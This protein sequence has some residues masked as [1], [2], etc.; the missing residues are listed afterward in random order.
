MKNDFPKKQGLYNPIFEHDS[1]GIG[2]ISNIKGIK[3]N[4]IIQDAIQILKSLTHR[5]GFSSDQKTGDGA[6]ILTQI[7]H[8]FMKKVCNNLNI[9]LPDE[10]NYAVGMFFCSNDENIKKNTLFKLQNVFN[11]E[12]LKILGFRNVPF[13]NSHIADNMQNSI[14]SILQVFI[15]KPTY[16][17]ESIDFERKLFIA[18]KLAQKQIRYCNEN[19]DPYFYFSSLSSKT[20]VYKGLLAPSQVDLFYTD[21]LDEDFKTSIA[22]VHSRFSTNT[23]PNWERAHPNKYI[24]HNGEINTIRGNVNWVRARQNIFSSEFF[25]Q[26]D[27]QKILPVINEDGSDSA[28]LDNYIQML[29]LSGFSLPKA[30]MMAIPEPWEKNEKFISKNKK[31][32]YQYNSLMCEPWD[33]PAGIAFTDGDIVGATLDRNGLRPIRYYITKDDYLILSSEVG[34]L[35]IKE[36]SIVLK[37]RLSAGQMLIVDTLK[38]KVIFDDEIKN[39]ISNEYPYEQWIENNILNINCLPQKQYKNL[40]KC[41]I[42]SL[43]KVFGYHK[44]DL[45]I[46]IKQLAKN[47][48]E[49]IGAMGND[50]PLAIFSE[51]SQLIYNYFKQLFAQ[52]T[53]PPIDAIREEIITSSFSYI[54]PEGNLLNQEKQDFKRILLETPILNNEQ[55]AKI[56]Y[57][58]N[59]YFKVETISILY[60]YN[61]KTMSQALDDFLE[62]A[63]K[64]VDEGA[65]I[66]IISDVGID[67]ENMCIPP[68][69]ASAG[70]HHHLIRKGTRT[71]TSIVLETGEPREV[72]HFAL[73]VG[74]GANAINP[75]LV[76][77]SIS[78]L[79]NTNSLENISI[80]SAIN[81]YIKGI[82]KGIIKVMSKMGISTLQSYQGA[83]IF[84]SIGICQNVIDKFFT[85]T[86]TRIEGLDLSHIEQESLMRFDDAFFVDEKDEPLKSFGDFSWRK[87]GEY[88]MFNPKTVSLLQKAVREGDYSLYKQYSDLMNS[89][90]DGLCTIRSMFK[91][92]SGLDPININEVEPVENIVKRFKTGAM[93]Y[94]ALSPEAH[95]CIAIGMN[96][97]GG[98]SNSGEGGEHPERFIPMENGDFKC[99]QIKQVA[100]GRFGVSI[101]YLKNANEIQIK[102]A[103]GAKPGEGGHL[104]GEKVYPWVAKVRNST[105]GVS[106][107][108]PPPHHD[109]YSI[110][111]LAQL[112]F[113]L[114]NANPDAR[115]SVKLVSEA[116]VGTIAVGVAKTLADVILISG[117]DGGTGAAPRTSIKHAGIPWEIGLAEVNQSLILNNLR[118]RVVLE[119]DGKLLTGRDVLVACLLGSEEFGFSTAPLIAIGCVM[120]RVCYA[121][122]CS[123][124]VA[125][126][127]P[128]LRKRFKGKPEH[129]ENFMR[130]IAQ[131]LR[132]YMASLGFK[133]IDEMVGKTNIL[134]I[135]E[136]D[137]FKANTVN[138][139]NILYTPKVLNDKNRIFNT[140]QN[141]NIDKTFDFNN[142][143]PI[144]KNAIKNGE[145]VFANFNISNVDRNCGTLLSSEI[146]KLKGEQGLPT[147]TINIE[148]TGSAGQSFGAF[149]TSGITMKISGDCNDY[150]GKGLS[151]GKIIIKSPDHLALVSN[152]NVIAGNVLLFGAIKGEAYIN[153]VVGERFCVRNSGATAVVEGISHHGLEYMTGGKVVILGKT[154]FNFGAGMSGGI[155]YVYDEENCFKE[156][157]NMEFILLEQLDDEDLISLKTLIQNHFNY[158]N[159]YIARTILDDFDN[160]SKKFVKVIPKVYKKVI[161]DIKLARA[162]GLSQDDAQM[163]AFQN[164]LNK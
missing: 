73:L 103:Q 10:N 14:P 86:P 104:P 115:I 131:E 6:G 134:K 37:E 135:K 85:N 142:L 126:Q 70:L 144:C 56:K 3:T 17:N 58:Q 65:N 102:L 124:G 23:F 120:L 113:D 147:D 110:E 67:K 22:L 52:V 94:G 93:S 57:L 42:L 62:L 81:N 161:N 76:F 69:L 116:G 35:P 90:N 1:C 21:L 24:I 64:K 77:D 61:L 15:E 33:G 157:C 117:Y 30:I 97:L 138:L 71:K 123:V 109:I 83:Q 114:K 95:E 54:G 28:M 87:D 141:H 128:E 2:F 12:N 88:H 84:E 100:S 137:N 129:I 80:E 44:E 133:T 149:L 43:Q 20:I 162:N 74:F 29:Y 79:I 49:P 47:A 91:F 127:D 164:I 89:H 140:Y 153:G 9:D 27:F 68:L 158:T 146:T 5:G 78:E 36:D 25:S 55:L 18:S 101:N 118:N 105:T 150:V 7:P 48:E 32:F 46:T 132:E 155:A 72:H 11:S 63:S 154:G 119:T 152:K 98:K 60:D 122:T 156:K 92:Y 26:Q 136:T 112:I 125:T 143:L 99:S 51:H 96:R 111:D 50:T 13:D 108:S 148:F 160:N 40:N 45:E 34:V 163:Q 19:Q 4:K 106:L 8:L 159:S 66:I 130:F 31:A 38:G 75:Y 16:I 139:S 107:I 53:N 121:N 145:K 59:D 39:Y 151:G 41:S 82:T